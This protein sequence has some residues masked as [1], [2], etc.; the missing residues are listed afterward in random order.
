M[1]KMRL[2]SR[3]LGF[4]PLGQE[5]PLAAHS[6]VLAWRIARTEGPGGLWSTGSRTAGH[7]RETTRRQL[8]SCRAGVSRWGGDVSF[9][10]ANRK[11]F[12]V[13]GSTGRGMRSGRPAP[14]HRGGGRKAGRPGSECGTQRAACGS[15]RE[16]TSTRNLD[17]DSPL[18]HSQRPKSGSNPSVHHPTSG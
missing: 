16:R 7:N 18:L 5:D 10:K 8:V 15:S 1:V 11:G 14:G 2:P 9:I 12:K 6:S 13:K 4:E 17:E 3:R